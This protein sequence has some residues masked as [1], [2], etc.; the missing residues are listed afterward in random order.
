MAGIDESSVGTR[1]GMV[2]REGGMASIAMGRKIRW[3]HAVSVVDS[4][5]E[6]LGGEVGVVTVGGVYC[7]EATCGAGTE[8]L[9]LVGSVEG[10]KVGGKDG[11]AL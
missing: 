9:L 10:H 4:V 3:C 6:L 8:H 5:A 11:I 2:N 7:K 1:H